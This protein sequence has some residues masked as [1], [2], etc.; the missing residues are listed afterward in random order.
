[1][2]LGRCVL[3][4][5]DE[6]SGRK[7]GRLPCD[8][9]LIFLKANPLN[10]YLSTRPSFASLEPLAAASGLTIPL[11]ITLSDI[12]LSAFIILVFSK[13][14]GVTLVFRND[15]L[16]S[17][18][19]SS[20]FDSIPF[21]RDYLQKEI[22]GQLRTLLMD[23]VPAIIH[24][25]SLRLWVP[26]YRARE[27]QELA[28]GSE[29]V[30]V[31]AVTDP[32]ASPP[33]DPVDLNGNVLD[34][35][36]IA[37]LSLDS[38]AETQSLFSQKNLLRLAALDASQRTLSLFTPGLQDVVVRAWA[39]PME[40]GEVTGVASPVSPSI[41]RKHSHIAS[42]ST[43]YTFS[44][45]SETTSQYSR[46]TLTSYGSSFGA[47]SLSIKH[48]KPGR[49]RKHRVVNLRRTK[50]GVDDTGSVSG[51]SSMSATVSSAR[52]ES[53]LHHGLDDE[54]DVEIITP[55]PSPHPI[56]QFQHSPPKSDTSRSPQI[57]HD[58]TPRPLVRKKQE[59]PKEQQETQPDPSSG[60]FGRQP[61]S[62][63]HRPRPNRYFQSFQP[64]PEKSAVLATSSSSASTFPQSTTPSFLTAPFPY[65]ESNPGGILEQ[66]WMMKM[67]GEIVR[68][69]QEQKLRDVG[70]CG[71]SGGFWDG[72]LDGKARNRE[73]EEAPPP[74]YGV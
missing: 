62:R 41:S 11:K 26:E 6:S 57:I 70:G 5:E 21:V 27:D 61:Q 25:L 3:D 67:A 48:G 53:G 33:Q 18:K 71:D 38:S 45:A 15:P 50:T 54:R 24:R 72:G 20:T 59:T 35:A 69:V 19:V 4:S 12:R 52:S 65:L 40:R 28:Q 63:A 68:R 66:A 51:E 32:L 55:P 8:P 44:N 1:M 14:K 10:T 64:P 34:A 22:E 37:S 17:L 9:V 74:A 60:P 42:T 56:S 30:E 36:Q 47:S 39:G 49:K 13:Q 73:E 2:L 23:E 7:N 58:T 16:E 29:G 43:T 46:P 31:E